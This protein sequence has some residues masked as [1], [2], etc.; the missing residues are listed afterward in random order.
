MIGQSPEPKI[1]IMTA[2]FM[3]THSAIALDQEGRVSID[4]TN[5]I[6]LG[7]RSHKP[8]LKLDPQPPR[9]PMD[10]AFLRR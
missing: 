8:L 9:Q 4:L 5:Q 3:R 6:R 7:Q 1:K 10:A 2:V